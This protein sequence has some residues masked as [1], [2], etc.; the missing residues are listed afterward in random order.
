M[1]EGVSRSVIAKQKQTI[2]QENSLLILLKLSLIPC[3]AYKKLGVVLYKLFPQQKRTQVK[4][5]SLSPGFDIM[6]TTCI[7][8]KK[9]SRSIF[10]DTE[11]FFTLRSFRSVEAACRYSVRALIEYI[12]VTGY[13]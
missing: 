3:C 1:V 4:I 11:T 13:I 12:C 9:R 10:G 5:F 7:F 2:S 8:G 6:C